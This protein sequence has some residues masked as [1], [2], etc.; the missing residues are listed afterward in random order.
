MKC[1]FINTFTSGVYFGWFVHEF[2]TLLTYRITQLLEGFKRRLYIHTHIHNWS[3]Q[4]FIPDYVT[5]L[6]ISLMFCVL[7]LYMNGSTDSLKSAQNSRFFK[8]FFMTI[9]FTL[10]V[11]VRNLQFYLLSEFLSV[12]YKNLKSPNK[13]DNENGNGVL[14]MINKSSKS[15]TMDLFT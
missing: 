14:K 2:A 6:L 3:L 10:R 15:K 11:F 7:N 4:S 5:W 8:N 1:T 12:I 9:L 13:Y